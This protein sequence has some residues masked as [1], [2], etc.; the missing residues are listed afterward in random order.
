MIIIDTATQATH[1]TT[2][3]ML[4]SFIDAPE[5]ITTAAQELAGMLDSWEAGAVLDHE[6]QELADYLGLSI[7]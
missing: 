7:R 3:G 4:E 2:N 1:N 6:A 5:E